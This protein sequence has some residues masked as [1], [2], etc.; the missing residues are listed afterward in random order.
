MKFVISRIDDDR[1]TFEIIQEVGV[2]KT[3]FWIK[4]AS[5]DVCNQTVINGFRKCGFRNKDQDADVQTLDQDNDEEFTNL[6]KELAGEVDPNDCV[7]FD[8][9][10]A[11]SIP[12]VDAGSIFWHQEIRKEIIGKHEN[13]TDE[14]MNV[15]SDEDLDEKIQDPE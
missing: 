2:L 15:S 3:I 12:A 13:P 14:V 5:E 1:K 8:K 11:S 10:I 4:A 7:D 9:D 6:V